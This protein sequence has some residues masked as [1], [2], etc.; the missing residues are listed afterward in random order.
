MT[1]IPDVKYAIS[2]D[3]NFL[4]IEQGGIE[5]NYIQ[6][7]KIHVKHLAEIMNIGIDDETTSPK[8]VDYLERINEQAEDLYSYLSSV[9]SFPPQDQP[10]EDVMMAKQLRDTANLALSFWGNN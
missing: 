9:P 10:S 1:E 6:L 4:N 3:G 8:L 5:P 2:D 7:H